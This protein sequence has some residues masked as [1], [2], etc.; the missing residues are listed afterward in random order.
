MARRER[1][2]AEAGQ[3]K[4]AKELGARRIIEKIGDIDDTP[5]KQ[6]HRSDEPALRLS[7]NG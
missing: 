4:T 1:I 7:G 3:R 2:E 5:E 6:A